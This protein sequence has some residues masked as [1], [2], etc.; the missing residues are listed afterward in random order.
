MSNKVRDWMSSPVIVVDPDTTVLYALTLMRRRHI[1]SAVANITGD[2]LTY[3]I[4][5]STDIFIA[6]E[7]IGWGQEA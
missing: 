2:S 3:G 5:T 7:E 1:H 4:S 6:D